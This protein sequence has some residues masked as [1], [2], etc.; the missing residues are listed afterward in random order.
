MGKITII[1]QHD[2]M[3][4]GIACLQMICKHFG[5]EYSIDSRSAGRD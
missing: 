4:C 5:K 3:Q 2:S 1:Y